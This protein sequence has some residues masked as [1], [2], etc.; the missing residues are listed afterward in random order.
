MLVTFENIVVGPFNF[1]EVVQKFDLRHLL[2]A[3]SYIATLSDSTHSWRFPR[4]LDEMDY[5]SPLNPLYVYGVEKISEI[6]E[7]WSSLFIRDGLLGVLYFFSHCPGPVSKDLVVFIHESFSDAVP[8]KWRKQVLLY[9]H[10]TRPLPSPMKEQDNKKQLLIKV[11]CDSLYWTKEE[12]N[13]LTEDLVRTFEAISSYEK[14]YF[15]P[16]SSSP[17]NLRDKESSFLFDLIEIFSK[18]VPEYNFLNWYKVQELQQLNGLEFVDLTKSKVLLS[19]ANYSDLFLCSRGARPLRD[20]C[21]QGSPDSFVPIGP[22]F[23]VCVSTLDESRSFFGTTNF[24]EQF[25]NHGVRIELKEGFDFLRSIRLP[26]PL[27]WLSL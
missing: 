6:I 4:T 10:C 1:K 16:I 25:E 11:S 20:F 7:T 2:E 19:A 24:L 21:L 3:Q 9:K 13:K 22:N 18:N 15:L 27:E 8:E 26:V 12:T 5:V 23:G 14:V 17:F